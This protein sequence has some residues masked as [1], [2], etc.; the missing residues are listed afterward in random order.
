MEYTIKIDDRRKEYPTIL[1]ILNLLKE[2]GCIS[3]EPITEGIVVGADD[4]RVF[5]R[6]FPSKSNPH[7]PRHCVERGIRTGKL[8]C[9]CIGYYYRKDCR[10]VGALS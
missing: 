10:H 5:V 8:V 2:Q 7:G 9:S 4:D 6:D 3:I 1:G